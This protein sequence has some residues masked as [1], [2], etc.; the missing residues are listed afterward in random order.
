M[1]SALHNHTMYSLLD[2]YASPEEYLIRATEIGLKAFAVTE[3]GNAY[4][5]CYFEKLKEKYPN[6]KIIYGVELYEAFNMHEQNKD[7]K[8][9]HL[10]ALA[11][12][13]AG[14]IAL[15]KIITKSNFEGFY[16]KNR[17]DLNLLK[18]YAKDL[19]ITSACLAS[20]LAREED[21]QK[22]IEY[23]KEYK[24]IFP[25]FYLEMQS[26]KSEQQIEYNKKILQLS[27]DTNTP[28]IITT[29]S[30]VA[31]ESDL[32]YQARHVQIAHDDETLSESYEGCYLQS[33]EEIHSVMDSQIGYQAVEIGLINTDRIADLIDIVKMPFQSPQ[34]PTF[35]LPPLFK[36][37]YSYIKHLI[38]IGWDKRGFDKLDFATQ[39]KYRERMEYELGVIHS[40]GFDGYFLIV[41]D[42]I[43]YCR[44]NDIMLGAGRGSCA[45]S[46]VSYTLFITDL[47]PIKYGLIFER[48]LNPE[49]ISMPDADIDVANREK[50]INYLIKKY[51]EERVCQVINFSFI[52]PVVAI[53]DVGKVLGFTYAE[54]DKLSKK[55]VYETF[56]ACLKHNKEYVDNNPQYAEL[57]DIASHLSGR[58]KNVSVHAGGVGIV[59]TQIT[60]YMPM[61]LG[62]DGE[63][64]IQVDKR[65]IEEIGIIKFDI[66]G[67]QTLNILKEVETDTELT[68]YDININNP[69][70]EYNTKPYE[71][72]NKALTNGVFQVESSGM[73]NLLLRLQANTMEDLSAVLAL[74]RPDSMGELNDYI[75]RKNGRK[76]IEYIH[77][78]MKPIL[79]STYGCLIYQEQLMDIVR[80]FGGRTYGGADK[81]RK[82]IGK[83]D[84]AL[85]R[86]EAEKLYYEIQENGYPEE[87]AKKIS[88]NLAEKGKYLFNRSHSFSY[89][90]LC[91]QTAFL[92]HFYPLYFFKA[93]FNLNKDK[94]GMI[95]KYVLDAKAFN[96]IVLPPNINKSVMNFSIYNNSILF[97]LSAIKGIGESFANVILE[98][99][100]KGNFVSLDDFTNR[101]NPS[102]AQMIALIKSGAIPTNDK[103]TTLIKYFK[104]QFKTREYKPVTTLPTHKELL[105]K[106]DIDVEDY[107]MSNKKLDNDKI[108]QI[109]NEK[110]KIIFEEEQKQRYK[111]FIEQH[112]KYLQNEEYW[113]FEAL[114]IFINKNPFDKAYEY[115]T[116]FEDVENGERCTIV[117]IISRVEKKKDKNKAQF[118]YVNIYSSFGLVEAIVWHSQLKEYEDLVVKGQQVAMLVRKDSE[119]K[120]ITE[121][122]KPYSLWLE[123]IK[124]KGIYI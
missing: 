52:T 47:D 123:Q 21:Y 62:T 117:G 96:I 89:A 72:L 65:I 55:F 5:W 48:F 39:L 31:N 30:H 57:F 24:N 42:F 49:R 22:C 16:Y 95:N 53:K 81:F 36:D 99:R 121:K 51:G 111:D 12:N 79:E 93:L 61:K 34:L 88:D 35:P 73:K 112:N 43:N 90:V 94:N 109:Y 59:D 107:R 23:I 119:E 69:V 82:G 14:R 41:W 87:I 120:V 18:P 60:D 71:L 29:D 4:S 45:G 97:G 10:I 46:L 11:K 7:C 64:V 86:K 75:E 70:F 84:E 68:E 92:K 9:F 105:Y 124:K 2:G 115:L 63:H 103:K 17:V 32:K 40:M 28:Y 118:A 102:K 74:Y 3:H 80:I 27:I 8:Y 101:I 85:V 110:K 44:D 26:H 25:H 56:E 76:P 91:F 58:I 19:I 1:S 83:K 78:D 113:E 50:V 104:S 13:E 108:L 15:N 122:I 6:V 33:D 100:K 54:M 38:D 116:P 37:N 77:P 106:W 114:Q 67:V 20:K 98:E 66:L